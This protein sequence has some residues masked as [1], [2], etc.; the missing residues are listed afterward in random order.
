V[1]IVVSEDKQRNWLLARA[2]GNLSI[3]DVVVFL[4]TARA[5]V[6]TRMM[7]LL[8][9]ARG[10]TTSMTLADVPTAVAVVEHAVRTSGVR[11][12]VALV[13]D[14]AMLRAW[15]VEYETQCAAIGVR[16]ICA[17]STV[18]NAQHWLEI[19]WAARYFRT[20]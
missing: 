7:P 9:D 19:V 5:G 15:F 1:P 16:V 12:N 4:R 10:C 11:A 8:V 20:P 6:H 18:E 13:A 14:D 3:D 2:T 17:F